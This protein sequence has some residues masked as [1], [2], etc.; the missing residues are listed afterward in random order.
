M[1][2]WVVDITSLVAGHLQNVRGAYREDPGKAQ[3]MDHGG[4]VQDHAGMAGPG[5]DR[6]VDCEAAGAEREDS[7]G[8][9][10]RQAAGVSAFYKSSGIYYI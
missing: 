6:R 3:E 9:H 10:E 4:A 8:T 7:E 2:M 1:T 5:P